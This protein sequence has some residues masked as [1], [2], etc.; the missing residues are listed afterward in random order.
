[1]KHA[2]IL[3]HP[4]PGSLCAGI[5]AAYVKAVRALGHEAEV[6]D[7]YAMGFDPR[8]RAGEIPTEAGYALEPDAEAER[9]RVG[10]ADVFVFVYPFWFNAPPAILKGY[11]DRVLSMGFGYEFDFGGTTGLL[12]GR[13]LLSFSTSGA[14]D[15][16]VRETGALRTLVAQFD[17]HLA[18][19]TGL[20]VADH[21][22]FGGITSALTK[23]EAKDVFKRVK[24]AANK[25]FPRSPGPRSPGDG[26]VKAVGV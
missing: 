21:I 19:V 13:Q 1:M 8:L 20:T 6:R 25:L 18:G 3:A 24:T 7:L 17:R 23:A 5:A 2:V 12:L 4:K 10:G 9:A 11:V 14:P 22:H 15:S 16:W 26:P